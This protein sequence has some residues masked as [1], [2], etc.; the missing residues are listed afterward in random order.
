MLEG[1]G[2]GPAEGWSSAPGQGH[3][4]VMR[5]FTLMLCVGVCLWE[6]GG[7][8]H[9]CG[10]ATLM[11]RWWTLAWSEHLLQMCEKSK[12]PG[13]TV[14]TF[15]SRKMTCAVRLF[16]PASKPA[17]YTLEGCGFDSCLLKYTCPGVLQGFW[18]DLL[19]EGISLTLHDTPVCI[20]TAVTTCFSKSV[21]CFPSLAAS[22]WNKHLCRF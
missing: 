16:D 2:I 21:I 6:G 5:H 11:N 17:R 12:V 8:L 13:D 9:P 19:M 20:L 4:A 3:P 1:I 18:A 22:F 10:H 14:E 7:W 15:G